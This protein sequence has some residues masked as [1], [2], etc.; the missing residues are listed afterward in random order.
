MGQ[1]GAASAQQLGS[2][3]VLDRPGPADAWTRHR[4]RLDAGERQPVRREA[5]ADAQ[6]SD[7]PAEPGSRPGPCAPLSA[8]ARAPWRSNAERTFLRERESTLTGIDP[9][10][11]RS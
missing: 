1:Q 5:A 7:T 8:E 4:A 10:F 6:A 9:I 3:R 2:A 11:E